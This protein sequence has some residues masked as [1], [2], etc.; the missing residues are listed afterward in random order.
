MKHMFCNRRKADPSPCDSHRPGEIFPVVVSSCLS[1]SFTV[2]FLI[3]YTEVDTFLPSFRN[4][5]GL[6]Y[7][8]VS[9][10][11][12]FTEAIVLVAAIISSVCFLWNWVLLCKEHI[13]SNERRL[14]TNSKKDKL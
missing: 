14:T 1:A 4:G 5:S 12:F 13:R 6:L 9:F 10:M 3:L 8:G 7:T 2:I 11:Y